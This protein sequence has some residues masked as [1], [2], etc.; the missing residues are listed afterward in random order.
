MKTAE[1]VE[2]WHSRIPRR[3]NGI[4]LEIDNH[5]ALVRSKLR[6]F[7]N[8]YFKYFTHSST[9]PFTITPAFRS[10]RKHDISTESKILKMI[11][12]DIPHALRVYDYPNAT[13]TIS[14]CLYDDGKE[15]ERISFVSTALVFGSSQFLFFLRELISFIRYTIDGSKFVVY[16]HATIKAQAD[17]TIRRPACYPSH[18]DGD[19]FEYAYEISDPFQ[20]EQAVFAKLA[21]ERSMLYQT[22]WD[23]AT[24]AHYNLYVGKITKLTSE[25]FKKIEHRPEDLAIYN[26]NY[27][28]ILHTFYPDEKLKIYELGLMSVDEVLEMQ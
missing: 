27:L 17:Q 5:V 14:L 21:G 22:T 23:H 24:S 1:L 20:I 3:F 11:R 8:Y 9:D 18:L 19:Q 7:D 2:S 10:L 6:E 16:G 12:D 4:V 25:M 26:K 28:G 15:Y 13:Y